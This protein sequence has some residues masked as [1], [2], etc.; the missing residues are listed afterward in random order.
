MWSPLS[1]L[2]IALLILI[3]IVY[4]FRVIISSDKSLILSPLSIISLVYV[5][6]CIMPFFSSGN[7]TYHVGPET[8][9]SLFH[10]AA[11]LSY[12]C[13]LISFYSYKKV[14]NFKVW[15]KSF[16]EGNILKYAIIFFVIA[17]AGYSAFRGVHFS[18]FADNAPEEIVHDNLEHYFIELIYLYESAFALLVIHNI[19]HHGM[20]WYYVLML[21]VF[22]IFIFAGTRARIVIL[23]ASAITTFQLFPKPRR[24]NYPIMIILAIIVYLGF[25][26]M[27]L[28][29]QY[30]RG[31]NRASL[32]SMT[33]DDI[34]GGANENA[35]V[36]WFSAV[37]MDWVE[38][39]DAFVHFEPLVNALISPIPRSMFPWKPDGRYL[40]EAQIKIIGTTDHGAIFLNFTEGYFSFGWVG[41]ILYGLFLGWLSKRFWSN[42]RNNPHSIG[43]II[44]LGLFNGYCYNFISRGYLATSFINFIYIVCLPF[45]VAQLF[46]SIYKKKG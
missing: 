17:F 28:S 44:A 10:V 37:V 32:N 6:Y 22:I 23:L 38:K 33:Y 43:A 1:V 25:S 5:Y 36:Y 9:I 31:L 42:Y 45:W 20:K 14:V 34:K 4:F 2:C 35:A 24:V 13:T 21:Y 26:I 41:V 19:K 8:N 46:N 3:I 40:M 30:S 7:E 39:E 29:R 15:N 27:D 16:N 18:I 12:I 11:L